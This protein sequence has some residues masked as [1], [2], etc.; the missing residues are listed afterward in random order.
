MKALVRS[1]YGG[2]EV[3]SV[4]DV[5]EPVLREDEALIRV[6]AVSLNAAD[7]DFL[8]GVSVARL[9]APFRPANRILGSDVAGRVEA[10]GAKV[11]LFEPGDEVYGDTFEHGFGGLAEM[12]AVPEEKLSPIPL[13]LSAEQAATLPQAGLLA[14]QGLTGWGGIQPRQRVLINGGGGGVGT[15]AIQLAKALGAVVTG[16]D[17]AA[18][19]DLMRSLGADEVIDYAQDDFTDTEERYD[20]VLDAVMSRSTGDAQ[21]ALMPKG[22]YVVVG[23]PILRLLEV[24]TLG[25]VR[26]ATSGA[27][28]RLLMWRSMDRVDMARLESVVAEGQIRPVIDGEYRLD[29]AV[30]AFERLAAGEA[31]GKLVVTTT[32]EPREELAPKLRLEG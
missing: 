25:T 31:Q 28:L 16:V 8:R 1:R 7:I 20:R 21:R 11:T 12:V 15:F 26:S 30:S 4:K 18:K 2:P 24:V 3:L 6:R 9:S 23:A 29:N 5:P 19:L 22:L 27:Q 10:V 14:W 32:V 17:S 13:G